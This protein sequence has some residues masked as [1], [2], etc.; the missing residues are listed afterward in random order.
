MASSLIDVS[1]L[2]LPQ[3]RF[4]VFNNNTT[5]GITNE[6]KLVVNVLDGATVIATYTWDYGVNFATW[7]EIKIPFTKPVSN[8]VQLKFVVDKNSGSP[9]YDD[10][11]VDDICVEERL[12]TGTLS[13]IVTNA[14]AAAIKDA[15]VSFSTFTT[16]TD[17]TGYYEFLGVEIGTYSVACSKAGYVTSTAAGVVVTEG[18]TTTQN[19]SLAYLLDPPATFQASILTMNDAHL[20]W[21]APGSVPDQWIKWDNGT[22]TSAIG[23]NAAAD[24]DVASRWPV[25]D[26]TSYSGMYL[27]K[28]RFFPS[29]ASASCTY[30]IKIWKGAN[31]ATLLY[32]QVVTSPTVGAFNDITLTTPVLIDGSSEF[33]FGYNVNTTTGYP[34]GCDAGPAVAGKGNM[35]YW[36][37]VWQELTVLNAALIGNWNLAGFVSA[38]AAKS[39]D[40]LIPMEPITKNRSANSTSIQQVAADNVIPNGGAAVFSSIPSSDASASGVN[41]TSNTNGNSLAPLGPW[42]VL[43]Y[44]VYRNGSKVNG[45][46]PL[47]D[48]FYDDL[49]LPAGDY[50]FGVT[51]VYAEGESAPA[52]PIALTVYSCPA[53]TLLAYSDVTTTDATFTWTPA[54]AGPTNWVVEYGPTGFAHGTGISVPVSGTSSLTVY[55]LTP[56]TT[57]DVYVRTDCGGSD[58]SAWDGPQTFTTQCATVST[59]PYSENFDA[60]TRPAIPICWSQ[61]S[62]AAAR[63]WV[64]SNSAIGSLSAPNFVGVFYSATAAK[65]EWLVSPAI[66]LTTGTAYQVKFWVQA[67]GYFGVPEKLKLVVSTDPSLSGMASGTVIW[68]D[69]NMLLDAYTEFTVPFTPAAAGP[70]YFGWYAYSDMDVDYIAMD[71]VSIVETPTA[72]ELDVVVYLEGPYAG[73]RTMNTM[74]FD[75]S[76]IPLAQP[77]NTAPWSYAGTESVVAVPADIVDWVLV[78]IRDAATPEAALPETSIWKKACFLKS[79]GQ[80]V[81]LDGTTLPSIGNP[82]VINNLYVV[83]RHRNHIAVMS[84]AG[85]ALNVPG[86]AYVFDFSSSVDQAYGSGAGFKE[87]ETGVFGMVAGDSDADG[88]I[89]AN[90]YTAWAIDFGNN[91]VY[92]SS[93]NDLDGDIG[94]NDYTKWAVNFGISNP[95]LAPGRNSYKSQVPNK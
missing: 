58:F 80:I 74:L 77:F 89:G 21:Q 33:W 12:P 67:P 57:Y 46:V 42:T 23:T 64:T 37:G 5:P 25:A 1:A 45:I 68:D 84:S 78:D 61:Y 43:G 91:P 76:L 22:N 29:V 44:N 10:M 28:V 59:F 6:Q 52:G 51:A 2:T 27:K 50:S 71:N 83:V 36:T 85:M 3:V 93:D 47:T 30:T 39:M 82:T 19:F 13:G 16:T 60:A 4:F 72:K 66:A 31:A 55:T 70:Y 69:P 24:F 14:A 56:A 87:I 48:L 63:P 54:V 38:S 53:A 95:I 11:I 15:T 8:L 92:F 35:I 20:T 81:D 32:S 49:D 62:S 41:M 65:D 88:D 17:P 90:D 73:S 40:P 75:N 79:D 94:A 7:Q 18:A 86:D 9:Y 34:A 26:I